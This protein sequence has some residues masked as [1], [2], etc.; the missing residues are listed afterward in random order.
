MEQNLKNLKMYV[1]DTFYANFNLYWVLVILLILILIQ[2]V[3]RA[4]IPGLAFTIVFLFAY[5]FIMNFQKEYKYNISLWKKFVSPDTFF[6][7]D[8]NSAKMFLNGAEIA[9]CD[10]KEIKFEVATQPKLIGASK[11]F[12]EKAFINTT[13]EIT[14]ST[15]SFTTPVQSKK[16]IKNLEEIFKNLNLNTILDV[17]LYNI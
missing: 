5:T 10:V 4:F 11:K 12:L 7:V 2:F 9:F 13:I 16:A 15:K 3:H 17:Q 6:Y 14:T 8:Y 1:R